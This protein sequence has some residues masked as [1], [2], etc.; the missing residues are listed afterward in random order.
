MIMSFTTISLIFAMLVITTGSSGPALETEMV[1]SGSS[2]CLCQ[3][4]STD[5]IPIEE[6][7]TV[8]IHLPEKMCKN[9]EFIV[10]LKTAK[11][12]CVD[13]KS[14]WIKLTFQNLLRLRS[15]STEKQRN[16]KHI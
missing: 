14:K 12:V 11:K 9:V 3:K 16:W 2:R 7:M 5:A 15:T 10:F 8:V 6:I 13:P 4:L 1:K